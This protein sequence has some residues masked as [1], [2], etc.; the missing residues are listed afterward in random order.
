LKQF[1]QRKRAQQARLHPLFTLGVLAAGLGAQ[2]SAQAQNPPD[3]GSLRRQIEQEQQPQLPARKA[4]EL[5]KPGA[6]NNF[7]P[8]ATRVQVKAFEFVG[9]RLMTEAE[10]KALAAPWVGKSLDMASL[11]AVAAA[12]GQAYRERGW[13]V[14]SLLP[15][16]EVKDGIIRIEIVEARFGKLTDDGTPS[17]RVSV[18]QVRAFV[19]NRLVHGEAV[20]TAPLD[21]GLML[22][23]DLPGVTVS[24]RLVQ[25]SQPNETDLALKITPEPLLVG[26]VGVDNFGSR[27]TG[28]ARASANLGVNSPFGFGDQASGS[29]IHTK[30]SDFV[31]ADYTAPIG[32]SGLRVGA[33]AS[34]FRYKL[35]QGDFQ[36]LDSRGDSSALGVHVN[37]PIIRTRTHN[38]YIGGAYDHR[39]FNNEAQGATVSNYTV[40]DLTA[41]A[42]FNGF[43]AFGGGGANSLG[44]SFI[45]SRVNLNG[46]HHQASA[47]RQHAA[48]RHDR[49]QHGR[50]DVRRHERRAHRH[51]RCAARQCGDR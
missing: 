44:L 18:E 50:E 33:D 35:V 9:N 25:G 22:A 17:G 36:A 45:T 43:D 38:F 12:V 13:V 31:R 41:T 40:D 1:D 34:W 24:G 27:S 30:G 32:A 4:G 15:R 47:D 48:A 11:Q 6:V 51:A 28:N 2:V 10:L 29:L 16:Q 49:R 3:A 14:R 42:N 7:L 37:Y 26:N 39:R 46:R 5:V 8:G 19:Q 23:D 21:R 20:N